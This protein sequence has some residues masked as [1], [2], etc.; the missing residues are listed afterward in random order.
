[1]FTPRDQNDCLTCHQ[2][3]Y[4][5][6]HAGSGYPTTCTG[7]HTPT[8]WLGASFNHTT[9]SGGRFTLVGTHLTKPCTV[10]HDATTG[11]PKFAPRDQNDCL[12]CH[13]ADYQRKHAGSGYPT[14]C[15]TCHTTTSFL[16]A[17]FNHDAN[18]FPI[19]SGTHRGRW[20]SCT[21]CHTVASDFS[22]FSCFGCHE[23]NQADMDDK[24]R[25]RTG[26]RYASEACLTCHPRP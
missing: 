11:A 14:T 7:C 21:I 19:N 13:Q 25:G 16:G 10:C 12:T 9:A 5:R 20:S 3:D 15:L 6:K 18:F 2:A 17:V 8:Q 23:H 26:Y 22:R 4:Q 1:L 24:H